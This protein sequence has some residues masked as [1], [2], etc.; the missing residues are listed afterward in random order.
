MRVPRVSERI[1]EAPAHALRGVFAGIGQLL[2]V[3]DKIR[4]KT[5]GHDVPAA[6][7]PEQWDAAVVGAPQS[8]ASA[9]PEGTVA[10]TAVAPADADVKAPDVAGQAD[11]TEPAEEAGGL[12]AVGLGAPE[13]AGADAA[14][15]PAEA[16]LAAT[17]KAAPARAKAART[18][19]PRTAAATP[20]PAAKA[21]AKVPGS[22]ADSQQQPSLPMPPAAKDFDRT[23][24]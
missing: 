18:S 8:R 16:K 7:T 3:S 5:P 12:A 20:T 4:H 23:G 10:G 24:N 15:A 14:S 22:N 6:R 19:K 11:A 2:L 13:K 1:K 17:E 9:E 21:P